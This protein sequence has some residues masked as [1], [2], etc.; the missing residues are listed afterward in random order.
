[1]CAEIWHLYDADGNKTDRT[2]VRGQGNYRDIPEGLYHLVV[3]FLILHEDGT[4]L[5]TKRSD[6]KD[7]YPGYWEASGGGSAILD[8]TPEQALKREMS[9]ETG[10]VSDDYEL[11]NI[12]FSANHGMFYSYLVRTSCD[13]DSIVLQEG[14]T[15]DYKWVDVKG[16]IDYVDSGKEFSMVNHNNRYKT[17][18]DSLRE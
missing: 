5:M 10:I 12:T 9:E 18:I 11:I 8:E 4:Y 7:V 3:D 13:K 6:V 17:Y 1:M 16:Y 14:E 15:V 2:F